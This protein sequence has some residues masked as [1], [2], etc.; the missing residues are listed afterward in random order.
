WACYYHIRDYYVDRDRFARFFS[1]KGAA[2][3][4]RWWNRMPQFDGLFDYQNTVRPSYWAFKLLSRL[5]GE[6]LSAESTDPAV[7]AFM[8]WDDDYELYNLLFWNFSTSPANVQLDWTGLPYDVSAKRVALDAVTGSNIEN[9]RL[10]PQPA[11][12]M[13]KGSGRVSAPLGPYGIEFWY[14]E[15]PRR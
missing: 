11:V 9:D 3:M 15:K 1:P 6:R 4:A 2:F 10:R 5:T 7:H 13:M 14:L 8:S 12:P